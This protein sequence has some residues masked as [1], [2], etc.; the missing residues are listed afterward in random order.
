[1]SEQPEI[2]F[3]RPSNDTLLVNLTGEWKLR[4]KLPPPEEPLL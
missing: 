1:M 2:T 4:R 3:H